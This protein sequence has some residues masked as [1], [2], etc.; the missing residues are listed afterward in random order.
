MNRFYGWRIAGA[1]LLISAIGTIDIFAQ[2]EMPR[3]VYRMK[4]FDA[5][6]EEAKA[7]NKAL[8]FIFTQESSSC[9]LCKHA[10][11]SAADELKSRSIVL[12][13]NSPDD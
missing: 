2:F 12:Y 8:A 7:K 1:A 4:D 5:A 13:A 6:K 10:S 11:L 3:S 9:G